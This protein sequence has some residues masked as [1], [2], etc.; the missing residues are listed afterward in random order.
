MYGLY[1]SHEEKW[2]P[3]GTHSRRRKL[4]ML[5][6]KGS[7]APA[8]IEQASG[9]FQQVIDTPDGQVIFPLAKGKEGANL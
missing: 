5:L 7:E 9:G 4:G 3:A 1:Q 2:I 6:M 8:S